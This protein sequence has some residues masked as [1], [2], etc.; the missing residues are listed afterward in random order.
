[1]HYCV[2]TH[3]ELPGAGGKAYGTQSTTRLILHLKLS[4]RPLKFRDTGTFDTHFEITNFLMA[5]LDGE[6]NLQGQGRN[7]SIPELYNFTV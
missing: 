6:K 2:Y 4:V 3:S 1:V 5:A 7:Q